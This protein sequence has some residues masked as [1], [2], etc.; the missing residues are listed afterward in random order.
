MINWEILC[1]CFGVG[2]EG[3]MS[4]NEGLRKL[5]ILKTLTL[6]FTQ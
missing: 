1:S 4:F 6:D 5:P 2:N 3:L